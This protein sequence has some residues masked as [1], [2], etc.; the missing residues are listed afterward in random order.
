M[1]SNVTRRVFLERLGACAAGAAAGSQLLTER[2]TARSGNAWA[3]PQVLSNPNILIILVDQMRWPVWLNSTQMTVLDLQILPNIFGK[4]RDNAYVFQQYYTAATVCSAARAT[5]LTGLYAPQSAVYIGD[6]QITATVPALNPAFPTW[7]TAVPALNSAYGGN[8]W[9]FGKWH[10]SNCTG[11]TPLVPYGLQTGTYPGGAAG[12]PSPNGA[13]N[14]GSNG[15]SFGGKVFASDSQIA[16]DFTAWLENQ[17]TGS[18]WCAT[19]SLINPHDIG[20]A[21]AWLQSNPFPP[22][23]V[24]RQPVYFPPPS[25]PPTPTVP[26]VYTAK[27]TPWNYE[28]LSKITNKPGLQY[29]FQQDL[30]S[31]YGKVADW[32]LFLNQYFWLQYYVDQ[33][34]GAILSAVQ[35]PNWAANTVIIFASDHGEFGGSH[36]L[37]DKGCAVYDE[38]LRVPL[39]VMFPG[40]T[41]STVMNQMCSS[42]DFFG[43]VCDL[44]TGGAG[45][46][47]HGPQAYP[48]LAS[49]QSIWNFLY[50]NSRETRIGPTLGIPYIFHT[51]DQ[52]SSTPGYSK[53]HIV[54][55]RTKAN[56]NNTAQPGAKYA[57]YSAWDNCTTIP[58]STPSDYEF[59]DYNPATS[60]NRGEM[61]NDYFSANSTT[62]ATIAQYQTELGT[63]GPP[64]TGLIATELARPLVGT[65]TDGNP[66]VQTQTTARQNYFNAVSGTGTCTA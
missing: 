51:C 49:R 46:W 37:H 64:A 58:N 40:Q 27:P 38:S 48:D 54:C 44:A 30:N 35:S 20:R 10:L 65:G 26:A 2:A 47:Q 31:S 52:T 56:P 41:G 61:G 33:Q 45:L 23:G 1:A 11:S 4:I 60:N 32:V 55:L 5:L 18:P 7:A 43:L 16:G 39:Y 22:T 21:P 9:W 34:V 17:P 62:T 25:F 6:D 42:V 28:D 13:A 29:V 3:A 24:A 19:V 66:L 53:A 50:H 59:Y 12:N 57:I 8:M 63:W 14:E 15:G 36:G